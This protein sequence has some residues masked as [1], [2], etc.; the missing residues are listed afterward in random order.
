MYSEVV[1]VVGYSTNKILRNA[2]EIHL[3]VLIDMVSLI[4]YKKWF[5]FTTTIAKGYMN[6]VRQLVTVIY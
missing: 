6:S 1:T 3:M 5:G 2:N 4:C